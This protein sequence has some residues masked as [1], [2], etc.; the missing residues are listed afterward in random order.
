LGVPDFAVFDQRCYRTVTVRE[1]YRLWQPTYDE[2]V[3][4]LM[5][6]AL[7]DRIT[8][9]EWGRAGRVADLGCGTGR[10]ARWLTARGATPIDGIDLTP[11]ML[12][13]AEQQGLH[14]RLVE[15]DVRASG[16][17]AHAYDVVIC[18]LVDE[19]LP[20]LA[21]LYVEAR[22]L[23]TATGSFVLVGYHPFFIMATGMPTHVDCSDGEPLAIETHVHLPSDH[24]GAARSAGLVPVEMH[25][26]V[27]DDD[28]IARKPKWEPYRGWPIS[29]A[30]VCVPG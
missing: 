5:D 14:E 27:I 15:A 23:V 4:D 17:P 19:H 30:W 6:I 13:A 18:A 24:M 10:T 16:L 20:E 9:V 7:L 11:Q 8:T 3:E 1:G 26:A 12:Q 25:E 29:F 22:R 21:P 2:T 28:W